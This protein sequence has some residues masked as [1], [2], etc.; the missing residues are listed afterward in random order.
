M[1]GIAGFYLKQGHQADA[2]TAGKLARALAHALEHRGPDGEGLWLQG[3]MA[4]VHRRLSIID[5]EGGR[6]PL[7]AANTT[8][9]G[10]MNGEIY[11]YKALQEQAVQDGAQLVT[12]SDSEPFFHRVAQV[13]SGAAL[14]ELQGMFALAVAQPAGGTLELAVDRFG[15]K[16]LY[17]CET[18]VGFAFA[19]E[20]KALLHAGWVRPEVNAPL[21]GGLL[22]KHS[23][24]GAETLF[25]GIF[26]LL[27]GEHLTVKDGTVVARQRRL[28][29]MAAP[30][31]PEGDMVAQFGARFTE[32]VAR[33]LVAD[34]PFGL[35]LSGGL[36]SS[37][38]LCAMK[39]LGAPLVAYTAHI[40]EGRVDEATAAAALC[41]KVGAE[42]VVVPYGEE[43]FWPG[44]VE[45]AWA[46]DDLTTDYAALPLLKL[47]R[48]ARADV[49][50]LLSGEGGDEMLGGYS[51]YRK[52]RGLLWRWKQRRAGDAAAFRW[53]FRQPV[54]MPEAPPL[55]W[56][57]AGLSEL[58]T[59]QLADV[60]GW[61]PH[62]LLLKLDRTTMVNGVEGRVPFLDDRFA[63]WAFALPDAA[64][65]HQHGPHDYGKYILRQH[66]E[67]LGHG[68]MAWARKQGFSVAVGAFMQRHP[69]R[70]R[71]MWQASETVQ[72]LLKPQAAESLLGG[73]RH[74]KTANLSFSLLLV[75][76]WELLHVQGVGRDEVLERMMRG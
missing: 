54:V 33:H 15:I 76:V 46:M 63:P 57:S 14:E 28:P 67:S 74:P 65:V 20:P 75:A 64:K 37:A 68:E 13:G 2:A 18:S 29:R 61:L 39:E 19:S 12:R 42:H 38:I 31:A 72:R 40:G 16:P 25:K 66:L 43:D 51:G 55:P 50:I 53:L 23:S 10:V 49:K 60:N 24:T 52:K 59:R 41:A 21:L 62:D 30:V 58:Q 44:V 8:V 56:G 4:L 45:M 1:C 73:L 6:Q 17:Y 32:A 69:G 47:T 22:N 7:F 9:A 35:L 70:V 3:A 5:V 36:D 48:R 34:V 71:A 11:N 26:R 27:P